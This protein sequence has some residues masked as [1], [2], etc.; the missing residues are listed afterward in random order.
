MDAVLGDSPLIVELVLLTLEGRFQVLLNGNGGESG[1]MCQANLEYSAISEID[2]DQ[3]EKV[4]EG[5]ANR[6]HVDRRML[7]G[8]DGAVVR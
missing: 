6:P 2:G 4:Q 3:R 5:S 8:G 1:A 7:A